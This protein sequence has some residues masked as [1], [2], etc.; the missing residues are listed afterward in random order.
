MSGGPVHPRTP[1]V[2]DTNV[3]LVAD[4]RHDDATTA[5]VLRC[6]A[7]LRAIQR[8]GC[9]VIDDH[10]RILGEY[11]RQYR[12]RGSRQPGVGQVFYKWLLSNQ[13]RAGCCER[14]VLTN[15]DGDEHSFAEY[16]DHPALE[17]FDPPDRKFIAVAAAHPER[18]PIAQALD[19][20]WW[21]LRDAFREA[22]LTIE[23]L[24]AEEIA[25]TYAKK[26]P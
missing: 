7:R 19:S 24:C 1:V 16:P 10:H 25:T 12:D 26:F 15:V 4:G 8:D 17:D 11:G 6:Q 22:D 9:V 14:V 20:K 23:F 2:V 5:C 13:G 21:G 3:I 18:P